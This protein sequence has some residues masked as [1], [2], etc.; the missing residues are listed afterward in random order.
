MD[1]LAISHFLACIA[2]N[3][4]GLTRTPKADRNY[5]LIFKCYQETNKTLGLLD[6]ILAT[7]DYCSGNQFHLGDIVVTLGVHRWILLYYTFPDKTGPRRELKSIERW[8]KQL[9][10]ETCFSE[11]ADQELI[12]LSNFLLLKLLLLKLFGVMISPDK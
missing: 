4:L 12:S 1:G 8:L 2:H 6:Q 10:A 9:R 5:D 7:Q 11:F 3:I